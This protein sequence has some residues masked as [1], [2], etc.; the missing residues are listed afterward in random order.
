M[1]CLLLPCDFRRPTR[2]QK[3]LEGGFWGL[4]GGFPGGVP[5]SRPLMGFWKES[6]SAPTNFGG[7]APTNFARKPGKNRK[8]SGKNLRAISGHHRN[9]ISGQICGQ[10]SGQFWGFWNPA[11]VQKKT[12]IGLVSL[13]NQRRHEQGLMHSCSGPSLTKKS[14]ETTWLQSGRLVRSRRSWNVRARTTG[15]SQEH[16]EL[17]KP[18]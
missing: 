4:W 8:I 17:V 3:A 2:N 5:E 16:R 6:P 15:P 14:G 11:P 10:I 7:R 13:P 9:Q 18:T 1:Q 12:M